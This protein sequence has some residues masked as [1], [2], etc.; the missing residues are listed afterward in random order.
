MNRYIVKKGLVVL[1]ALC[2]FK[3]F[4]QTS[5]FQDKFSKLFD[6]TITPKTNINFKEYYE[7]TIRQSV[8]HSNPK[9]R[10]N[11]R[12]YIG[13]QNFN[14][15]TVMVTDG[16]A[17]DYASRSDY[18]NEL[19][20]EL[21]ANIVVIEH[22]FFGKSVPDSMD[23]KLLTVKQAADDYHF[24]KSILEKLLTG[25]WLCT[26]ISKGGQAALSYKMYYPEDMTGAVVY[27]TAVKSKQVAFTDSILSDLSQTTPGKK[28]GGL[29]H[30]L[31]K[32]K[33]SLLPYFVTFCEQKNFDFSPLDHETVFDFLL[34]ELPFSFWQNGNSPQ[35]IPDSTAATSHLLGYLVKVVHPR[36]FSAQNKK[37]LEPAFYMFYHE[38]GY[39]EY[40][41]APFIKYLK[42]KE[43]SNKH[44]APQN[45]AIQFDNSYQKTVS[46]FV[47]STDTKNVLF[48]YGQND[49]W[50]LQTTTHKNSFWVQGGSHK[51]R[52]ADFSAEQQTAIY[53]T[54]TGW[55]K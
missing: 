44:F 7:I 24:I 51:S 12:I 29:Q 54:I 3:T 19:A 35:D 43:Y 9:S 53:N 15:A 23:W 1:F 52:I 20:K 16:Y 11:Q 6:C 26:G 37:E 32:H 48:I 49:P 47:N 2:F 31:F 13:F 34:L 10:F 46:S 21:R 17:I 55:L 22:R 14:A 28:I 45:I 8:D 36:F 39:Y 5:I 18:T 38:L 41:T 42:Q 33:T 4:S 40:H 27:G 30:Y 25:K 50:A